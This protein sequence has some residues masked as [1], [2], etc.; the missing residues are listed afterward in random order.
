MAGA[1]EP[2]E[3][4]VLGSLPTT[5]PAV[6]SPRRE[7]ARR[8]TASRSDQS[9]GGPEPSRESPVPSGPSGLEQLAR[10]G[11]GLVSG[12]AAAGL[13]AVGRAIGRLAGRG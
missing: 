6:A 8:A 2:D 4:E 13:G 9:R 5:R 3:S 7:R 12:A 10:S 1:R 11:A